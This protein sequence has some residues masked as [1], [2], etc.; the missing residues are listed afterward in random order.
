MQGLVN[1]NGYTSMDSCRQIE[2]KIFPK[3]GSDA[4]PDQKPYSISQSNKDLKR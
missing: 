3:I 1:Q 2:C 4:K